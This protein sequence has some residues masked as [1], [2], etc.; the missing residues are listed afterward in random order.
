M[1]IHR[2]AASTS[3]GP[4]SAMT[5]PSALRSYD[6]TSQPSISGPL[7]APSGTYPWILDSGASFH[8]TLHF[9]HL[10]SLSSSRHLTAYTVDGSSLSVAG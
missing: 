1:L 6:T 9:A 10:S 8:M 4:V 2:L 5:Q 7:Y 3:S